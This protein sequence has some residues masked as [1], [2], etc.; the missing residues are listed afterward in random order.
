MQSAAG[1]LRDYLKV[2]ETLPTLPTA[3]AEAV[4]S[5]AE[6]EVDNATPF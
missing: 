3:T 1:Y 5:A 6:Q 4:T 2:R